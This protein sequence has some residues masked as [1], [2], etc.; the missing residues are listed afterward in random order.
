V[1]CTVL[2]VAVSLVVTGMVRYDKISV[3]APPAEAFRSAGRVSR[4]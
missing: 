2:N 3:A 1:I 4:P